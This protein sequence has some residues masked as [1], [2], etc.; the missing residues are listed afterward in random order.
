MNTLSESNIYNIPCLI[1]PDIYISGKFIV[2]R[3]IILKN[4]EL[5]TYDHM[6]FPKYFVY[7]TIYRLKVS[8]L[9]FIGSYIIVI[10]EE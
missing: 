4:I 7:Y 9:M 5:G 3:P 10:V 2:V 8:I 6:L 1:G